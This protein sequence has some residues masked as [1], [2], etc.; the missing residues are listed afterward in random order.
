MAL[1][2]AERHQLIIN[3]LK[4]NGFVNVNELS[5]ELKVSAV[6]IRKDL[7]LLEDRKLLFRTHGSATP[8]NPYIADRHVSEKEKIQVDE[9][10]RIAL[11]AVSML[12]PHDSI[13]L[14]SGTTI[15]ELSRHISPL[16]G[17]TLICASLTASQNLTLAGNIDIIQLGGLVRRTSSSVVGPLA[18]K[19]LEGFSCSKLFLGADGIDPDYGITTTNALEASLNQSMMKAAQKIILLADGTKFGRRGFGKICPTEQVD[20]IITDTKAPAH[21]VTKLREKGIEVWQV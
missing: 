4:T 7:K 8:Q 21:V 13:I 11:K 17:L 19:M 5:K 18:E 2:I 20:M 3:K 16:E 6:T 15:N 10:R 12:E 1:S 9:K 14:A